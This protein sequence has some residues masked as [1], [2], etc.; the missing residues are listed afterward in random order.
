MFASA[1]IGDLN[2][3]LDNHAEMA[4]AVLTSGEYFDVLG[5]T[6]LL[7]RRLGPQDDRVEA[8]A[9]TTISHARAVAAK[10][11][12]MVALMF[13]L[14][15]ALRATR[16]SLLTPEKEQ[17]RGV[18]RSRTAGWRRSW[19]FCPF[20]RWGSARNLVSTPTALQERLAALMQRS[21]LAAQGDHS[22][23]PNDSRAAGERRYCS[24]VDWPLIRTIP[25]RFELLWW[26]SRS[27]LSVTQVRRMMP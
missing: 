25:T 15:P 6:A 8:P 17:G 3:I 19:S 13:S 24:D 9:V 16:G 20:P 23:E 2:V 5:V 11:R 10:S 4:S 26:I 21:S 18:A 22:A 7:G 27:P 12:M 14:L 1:P